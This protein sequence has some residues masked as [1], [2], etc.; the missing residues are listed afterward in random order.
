MAAIF[1]CSNVGALVRRRSVTG[2]GQGAVKPIA[3]ELA[4]LALVLLLAG[5]AVHSGDSRALVPPPEAAAENFVRALAA[6]R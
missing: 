2:A 6:S 3:A 4:I 5:A 1:P